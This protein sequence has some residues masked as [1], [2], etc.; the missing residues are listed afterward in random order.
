MSK[1]IKYKI[2]NFPQRS[3]EWYTIRRGRMTAS[4]AQAIGNNGKGLDTYCYE[5]AAEMLTKT[6]QSPE[7]TEDMQRGID[8]E[9]EARGLFEIETGKSVKEIGFASYEE[10]A[11]CSPDGLI[12][13]ENALLEIKCP[14]NINYIKLLSGINIDSKYIWQIQM[15]MAIL[16]RDKT[17]FVA[18]NPNFEKSLF[19]KVIESDKDKQDSI[20]KGIEAGK[21]KIKEIIKKTEEIKCK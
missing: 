2:H 20:F 12:D 5:L 6:F 21:K 9:N 3:E 14:N 8:L 4:N 10:Y 15:Q 19:I 16:G 11:G 7:I 18:Y 1:K 13:E 17:Y